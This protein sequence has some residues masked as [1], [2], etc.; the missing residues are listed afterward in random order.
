MRVGVRVPS[1]ERA[2][3]REVPHP[4]AIRPTRQAMPPVPAEQ[5]M[6]SQG[7][8]AR[9]TGVDLPA[10]L[11]RA[12]RVAQA[13]PVSLFS[14]IHEFALRTLQVGTGFRHSLLVRFSWRCDP[15]TR[16]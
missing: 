6:E 7:P 13:D 3:V 8:T 14:D 10:P 11:A 15:Q 5:A 1:A 9:V 12:I 16:P 2:G 4:V